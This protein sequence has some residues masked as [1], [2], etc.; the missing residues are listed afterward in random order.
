MGSCDVLVCLDSLSLIK[1]DLNL[2]KFSGKALFDKQVGTKRKTMLQVN[3]SIYTYSGEKNPTHRPILITLSSKKSAVDHMWM[4]RKP[5]LFKDGA[6]Y[7]RVEVVK[8]GLSPLPV[9]VEMKV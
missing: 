6:V 3:I 9:I 5:Y 4:E 8:I 1:I 2:P 7:K